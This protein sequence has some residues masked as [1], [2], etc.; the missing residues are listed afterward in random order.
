MLTIL[1][2]GGPHTRLDSSTGFTT[3]ANKKHAV[4]CMGCK[5]ALIIIQQQYMCVCVWEGQNVV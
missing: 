1:D 4:W 2:G 3:Q 5:L